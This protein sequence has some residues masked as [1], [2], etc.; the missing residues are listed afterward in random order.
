MGF[1][2]AGSWSVDIYG[3]HSPGATYLFGLTGDIPVVGNWPPPQQYYLTTAVS[4]AGG[5]TIS[6]ACPGGCLYGSGSQVT[7]NAYPA[8]GYQFSGFTGSVS[9]GSNPLVVTMNSAMTETAN[10]TPIQYQLTTTATSGGTVTPNC[11]FGCWYN[12][13]SV[14]TVTATPTAA[15]DSPASPG[16]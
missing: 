5:G 3:N 15:F 8:S 13:G 11:P 7:I 12:A 6:P 9:S 2:Y 14:V 4:P 1:Y 10:F 16:A